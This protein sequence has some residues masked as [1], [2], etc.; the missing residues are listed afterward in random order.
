MVIDSFKLDLLLVNNIEYN[1]N[2]LILNESLTL[3][4]SLLTSNRSS[5][6]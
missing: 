3:F 6:K 5:S 4:S 2:L 1:D